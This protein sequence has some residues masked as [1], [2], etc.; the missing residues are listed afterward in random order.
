MKLNGGCINKVRKN[1]C[2]KLVVDICLE[3]KCPFMKTHK[4]LEESNK[5]VFRRLSK[6]DRE[7]QLHIS[8]KYYG[9]NM[10][11]NKGERSYDY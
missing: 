10:P 8:D 9:G 1:K 7:L 11:W 4:Q 3:D 6:L 2:R 5:Y